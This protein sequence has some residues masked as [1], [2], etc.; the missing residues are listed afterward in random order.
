MYLQ[1]LVIFVLYVTGVLFLALFYPKISLNFI[2]VLGLYFGSL[3]NTFIG[4]VLGLLNC[5]SELIWYIYG[6]LILVLILLIYLRRKRWVGVS[7]RSIFLPFS[8]ML[9]LFA[10]GYLFIG[11]DFQL[12][13]SSTSL[14]YIIQSS[15]VYNYRTISLPG[16]GYDFRSQYGISEIL[17]HALAQ[18]FDLP[19]LSLWHPFLWISQYAFFFMIVL[20]YSK[21]MERDNNRRRYGLIIGS[22][23]LIWTATTPMNWM[24]SFYIHVHL[25]SSFSFLI[26]VYF[27]WKQVIAKK[28]QN[29][30]ILLSS[31]AICAYGLSRVEAPIMILIIMALALI[32]YQFSRAEYRLF[33]YPPT[34]LMIFWLSFIFFAYRGTSTQYWSDKRLMAAI[35]LYVAVVVFLIVNVKF[36]II[37]KI[38]TDWIRKF[39]YLIY[40]FISVLLAVMNPERFLQT[41]RSVL[42]NMFGAIGA[43]GICPWGFY[44]LEVVVL[45]LFLLARNRP[46]QK[47][48]E[49]DGGYFLWINTILLYLALIVILGFFRE[50]PYTGIRWGDS[51]SRM[52]THI[53][54]VINLLLFFKLAET[55]N[56]KSSQ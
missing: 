9:I 13:T 26:F 31:L 48:G 32:S 54:P 36:K 40:L 14:P 37:K 35:V 43:I 15:H 7:W 47:T 53:S 24:Q 55:F 6:L 16:G 51:A 34:A 21:E 46:W 22:L 20:E 4:I 28:K 5:F 44:W 1:I 18:F 41:I 19:A 11:I 12:L 23:I 8:F 30:F 49:Q 50:V 33:F 25:F 2:A 52:L 56:S 29:I 10:L 17:I 27:F 38:I 45:I 39:A 42:H 3:I